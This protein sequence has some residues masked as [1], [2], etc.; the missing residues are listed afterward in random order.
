MRQHDWQPINRMDTPKGKQDW[1]CKHCDSIFRYDARLKK[2]DVMMLIARSH[3][4]CQRPITDLSKLGAGK[5]K[6]SKNFIGHTGG[7]NDKN[8]KKTDIII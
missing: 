5:G 2:R 1:H 8:K 3:F 4:P 6:Q 7:I